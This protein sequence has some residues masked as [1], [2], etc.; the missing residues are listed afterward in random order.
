LLKHNIL[1][2]A[3]DHIWGL[4]EWETETGLQIKR[5]FSCPI[6]I[7]KV[8]FDELVEAAEALLL[9]EDCHLNVLL[10]VQILRGILLIILISPLKI[11]L[12]LWRVSKDLVDDGSNQPE[13]IDILFGNCVDDVIQLGQ[14]LC[15]IFGKDQSQNNVEGVLM[16]V[17]RAKTDI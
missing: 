5:S 14:S 11:F 10:L 8:Y 2:N 12:G 3:W 13:L 16:D 17:E 6:E 15:E 1:V 4:D 9:W 7:S